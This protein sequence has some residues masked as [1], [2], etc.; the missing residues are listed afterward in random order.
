ML[1]SPAMKPTL[2][3]ALGVLVTGC[4]SSPPRAVVAMGPPPPEKTLGV[5]DGPLCREQACTCRNPDDVAD[6][7]AGVPENAS[8]KRFEL[9]V[10]PTDGPMWLTV[11]DMVFFKSR[12]RATD[13]FY[14][15]LP[16]GDHRVRLRASRSPGVQAA[17]AISE[18][19]AAS[20][21]WYQSFRF[22]CGLAGVCSHE[23]L[24]E[25][26]AEYRKVRRG[27]HDDCGSVKIKGLA[28][29]SGTAPDRQHPED[30]AVEFTLQ[31]YNF[32]PDKVHGDAA[33]R[34]RDR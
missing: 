16:S 25:L 28:W 4:G 30:L 27:V 5:L 20:K 18:Y 34:P 2:L 8:R 29:D 24:D 6:G 15:D 23:E 14:V 26:R 12:E 1:A 17:V 22:A 32:V 19:G 11:D 33:C 13:C 31:I 7:G 9:R 21:S 3:A 10:G